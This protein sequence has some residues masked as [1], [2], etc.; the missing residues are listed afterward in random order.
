VRLSVAPST[1]CSCSAPPP[2]L[3]NGRTTS[4]RR[5]VAG[6][7]VAGTIAGFVWAGLPT[8]SE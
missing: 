7:S 4:E 3:A 5:G 8:S 2:I 6:F 1:K